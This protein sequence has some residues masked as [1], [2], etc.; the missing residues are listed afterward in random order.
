MLNGRQQTYI[1]DA[2]PS[3]REKNKASWNNRVAHHIVSDFYDMPAFLAGRNS[4]N[5]IELDLLGNI[6]GK[7]VLHLQ[8]HFG[9]DSISL[10]RMGADVTGVDFSDK[11]IDAAN[12]LAASM[13]INARFI[14]CDMYDLPGL[15]DQQFDI[16][17]TSYG[18]ITWLPD[19]DKWAKLISRY[20]KPG[21]RLVFADFHPV[22][23]MYDNDF[24]KIVYSYFKDQ[25]IIAT[26]AGTYADKNAPIQSECIT[27]NHGLAET[28]DSLLQNGLNIQALRE[29]DYSPY[30]CFSN[31]VEFEPG[32][33]RIEGM[34]HFLPMVF[35]LAAVKV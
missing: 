28:I 13:H 34:S 3:Y 30:N 25:P 20:L 17:F 10:A 9:Q 33:F 31:T 1:M 22:V 14:C 4:L 32:K 11:A 2:H 35:A 21:G 23:W 26:E 27:W 24:S 6:E 12:G 15:L 8:C 19:L 5:D 16:I 7:A 29:Y 18:T